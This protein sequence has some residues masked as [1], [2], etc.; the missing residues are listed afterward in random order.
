MQVAYIICSKPAYY[1]KPEFVQ[2]WHLDVTTQGH[3]PLFL[4]RQPE[5]YLKMLRTQARQGKNEHKRDDYG[6]AGVTK[7]ETGKS[8]AAAGFTC[9]LSSFFR[10]PLCGG[11]RSINK[12]SDFEMAS[13][14]HPRLSLWKENTCRRVTED[15]AGTTLLACKPF[16]PRSTSKFTVCPSAR[17]LNPSP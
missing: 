14:A 7:P 8:D 10:V 9:I 17:D 6:D 3:S 11:E 16:G 12:R 1:E 15:Q 5:G 13:A 4:N 2:G